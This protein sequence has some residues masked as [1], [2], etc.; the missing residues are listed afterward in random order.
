MHGPI[1]RVRGANPQIV[2]AA[3]DQTTADGTG[4]LVVGFAAARVWQTDICSDGAIDNR[5][6]CL[7]AAE[8][9]ARAHNTGSHN[10]VAGS[11]PAYSST[12]GIVAGYHNA[13]TNTYA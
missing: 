13:I 6:D 12:G 8:V 4:N 5:D 3:G 11:N 7:E 9:W 2:N 10:I 1:I